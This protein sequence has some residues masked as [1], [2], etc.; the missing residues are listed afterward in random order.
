MLQHCSEAVATRRTSFPSLALT[1][2]SI[3]VAQGTDGQVT[4]SHANREHLGTPRA[5]CR[6]FCTPACVRACVGEKS[7]T[8]PS[9]LF[10]FF[11]E[12]LIYALK[13]SSVFRSMHLLYT[14]LRTSV[15]TR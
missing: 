1:L 13:S 10:F 6:K 3:W 11:L 9:Q 5:S 2:T 7:V 14:Y 12:V 15:W 8:V 4:S